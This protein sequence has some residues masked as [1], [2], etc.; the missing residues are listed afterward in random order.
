MFVRKVL[1][2]RRER[3]AVCSQDALF[4]LFARAFPTFIMKWNRDRQMDNCSIVMYYRWLENDVPQL[5]IRVSDNNL[6]FYTL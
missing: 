3:W 6:Q 4:D 2:R 1:N 5:D